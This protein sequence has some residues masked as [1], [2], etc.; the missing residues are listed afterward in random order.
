M[1]P[2][3]QPIYCR[4]CHRQLALATPTR[5]LFNVGCVCDEP[6]ALKCSSCGARRYWKPV[7]IVDTS[8]ILLP[9]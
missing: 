6:V 1:K 5:L 2:D 4:C 3:Y 9:A 8:G 7:R